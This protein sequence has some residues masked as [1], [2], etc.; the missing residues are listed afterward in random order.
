MLIDIGVQ[1]VT[2][3]NLSGKLLQ[4]LLQ[5]HAFWEP[6]TCCIIDRGLALE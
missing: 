3:A 1:V 2:G 4:A 5:G 6:C